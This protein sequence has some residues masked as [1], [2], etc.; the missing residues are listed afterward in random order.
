MQYK[1]KEFFYISNLLSLSRIV[2]VVPIVYLLTLDSSEYNL[3]IIGLIF[4]AAL[5]DILDGF[6]SRKLNIVTELGIVLDPIA[7]KITMAV[8]LFALVIFRDFYISL[9]ILLMY[10]DLLIVI[11]GWFVVKKIEKPIMANM[12]GKI[13]TS[14]ITIL[15]LLF[16]LEF[17]NY[18]Y[19]FILYACYLSILISGISYARVADKALFASKTGKNL[20]RISLFL[21]TILVLY[22][23]LQIDKSN[24]INVQQKSDD[25]HVESFNQKTGT[26]SKLLKETNNYD[27]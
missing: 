20:Y 17:Y 24:G 11:M 10:R 25:R 26:Y 14:L 15:A 27:S 13:N 5:T 9:V 21:L 22:F 12:W 19:T 2:L 7:D 8:I 18:F 6:L 3:L 1:F 23:V 4:I 16:L